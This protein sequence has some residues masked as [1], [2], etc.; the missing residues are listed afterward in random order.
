MTLETSQA[1][2]FARALF[3]NS[4][5]VEKSLSFIKKIARS[6]RTT[7]VYDQSNYYYLKSYSYFA[8]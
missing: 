8:I 5:G 7:K 6:D 2:K 1:S 3:S 4:E